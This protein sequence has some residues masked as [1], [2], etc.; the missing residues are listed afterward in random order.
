MGEMT[1]KD[2]PTLLQ[3]LDL[4]QNLVT[5]ALETS[6]HTVDPREQTADVHAR[7]PRGPESHSH[8]GPSESSP[9][10]LAAKVT[11]FPFVLTGAMAV[12]TFDSG[13]SKG[14]NLNETLT[15]GFVGMP[16]MTGTVRTYLLN[17]LIN[18]GS[19]IVYEVLVIVARASPFGVLTL[20]LVLNL[21]VNT[22]A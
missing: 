8:D 22:H 15:V 4:P 12:K 21:C 20:S 6:A 19:P 1:G 5:G 18:V 7:S 17:S 3:K 16:T 14:G 11:P 9:A 2:A 10:T 13:D